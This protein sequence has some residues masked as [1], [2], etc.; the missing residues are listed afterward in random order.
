M[1]NYS[2]TGSTASS[3]IKKIYNEKG[4]LGFYKGISAS[5]IG[6]LETVIYFVV[7]EE[8]KKLTLTH[9]ENYSPLFGYVTSSSFSK[10]FAACA[11]YPHGKLI[12]VLDENPPVLLKL[13]YLRGNSY[14]IEARRRQIHEFFTN[15]KASH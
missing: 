15:S 7:Y 11:C 13:I 5:Y 14:T 2:K 1:L 10:T 9:T 8:L 6:I 12:S 4:I 3:V